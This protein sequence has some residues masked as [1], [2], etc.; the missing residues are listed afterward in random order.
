V[1]LDEQLFHVGEFGFG[2]RQDIY[3]G[4]GHIEFQEVDRISQQIAQ[5]TTAYAERLAPRRKARSGVREHATVVGVLR[6]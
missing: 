1:Y 6:Q 3:F 5:A 4:A 2:I